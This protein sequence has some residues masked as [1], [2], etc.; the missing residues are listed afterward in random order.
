M[1]GNGSRPRLIS[2]LLQ[3]LSIDLQRMGLVEP[4]C[5]C[6]LSILLLKEALD[7]LAAKGA[8]RNAVAGWQVLRELLGLEL[9]E[10]RVVEWWH[11]RLC[12]CQL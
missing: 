8:W 6:S 2:I 10:H 1:V 11:G 4:R 9:A 7:L 12:L 5:S 3:W